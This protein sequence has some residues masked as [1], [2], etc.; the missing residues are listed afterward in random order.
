MPHYKCVPEFLAIIAK[1]SHDNDQLQNIDKNS[2]YYSQKLCVNVTNAQ[3]K[4]L[5]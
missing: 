1:E 4:V 2:V 5:R 3:Y